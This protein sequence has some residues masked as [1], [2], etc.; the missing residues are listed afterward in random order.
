M[1]RLPLA[2]ALAGV[3]LLVSATAVMACEPYTF[4]NTE[5]RL[6]D[7][8]AW[9]FRG[10]VVREVIGETG[11]PTMVDIAVDQ[12][13]KGEASG[14][15]LSIRQDDGCDGFWYGTGDLVIVALPRY[16]WFLADPTLGPP[17]R[18]P[19]QG[20][21]NYMAAVWVLDGDRV[22]P[23]DDGPHSWPAINGTSP[24]TVDA[25]IRVLGTLPDTATA[26]L[27]TGTHAKSWLVPL[28]AGW[29]ALG[30]AIWLVPRR[31]RRRMGQ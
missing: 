23:G 18:S 3:A 2:A 4:D 7:G 11:R 9:A 27:S 6:E 24:R 19:Y 13:L 14:S 8:I 21:T 29:L 28:V 5:F 12:T 31:V 30:G 22:V 26:S 17:L 10:H 16:P 20:L 25:L 1:G 15:E